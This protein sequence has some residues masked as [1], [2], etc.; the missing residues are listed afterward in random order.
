MS[1]PP[2]RAMRMILAQPGDRLR[3]KTVIGRSLSRGE[4]L[5]RREI[6]LAFGS[7]ARNGQLRRV[8]RGLYDRESGD[9]QSRG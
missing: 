3:V 6:H 1:R 4:G 9:H 7:L 8:A 5:T 2:G